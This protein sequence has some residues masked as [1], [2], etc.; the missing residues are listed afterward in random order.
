MSSRL[1]IC[2]RTSA[3][4][5][6]CQHEKDALEQYKKISAHSQLHVSSYGFFISHEHPYF[7]ASPDA[8]IY[9]TCCGPR[10]SE[11]KVGDLEHSRLEVII[12]FLFT[13]YST[14]LFSL[15]DLLFFHFVPIIL[16][17]WWSARTFC[18]ISSKMIHIIHNVHASYV[19]CS[20]LVENFAG[21]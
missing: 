12:L 17:V 9:C 11:V 13:H 16:Y 5:Y 20:T 10:I 21:P 2:F 1:G 8:V 18:H 14:L 6:G 3:T 4:V 7:R 15:N 19:T